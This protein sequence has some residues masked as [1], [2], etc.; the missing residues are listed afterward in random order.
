M[1]GFPANDMWKLLEDTSFDKNDSIK[2]GDPP[3]RGHTNQG[4]FEIK[5]APQFWCLSKNASKKKQFEHLT[6]CFFF[7][8]FLFFT[9][10]VV[11][12]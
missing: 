4:L 3:N 1:V 8:N 9:K 5:G 12:G 7:T 11:F 10:R 2:T 6:L